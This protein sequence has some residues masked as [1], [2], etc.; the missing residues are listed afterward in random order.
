M[1]WMWIVLGWLGF[2]LI[3]GVPLVDLERRQNA[4][5]TL[6]FFMSRVAWAGIL[7]PLM[8]L[9]WLDAHYPDILDRLEYG[10]SR[11]ASRNIGGLR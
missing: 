10:L 6:G 1:N 3:V 5:Y 8:V 2:G 9:V 7:G 11:V 4:Y